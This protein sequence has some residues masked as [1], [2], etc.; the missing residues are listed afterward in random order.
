[1]SDENRRGLSWLYDDPAGVVESRRLAVD[2]AG[3]SIPV[4]PA[5]AAGQAP[6]AHLAHM[7]RWRI[8]AWRR[9]AL[10]AESSMAAHRPSCGPRLRDSWAPAITFLAERL[11]RTEG[12]LCRVRPACR[13][14]CSMTWTGACGMTP[15]AVDPSSRSVMNRMKVL[16]S[17]SC[18][19]A[20]DA[21]C[22]RGGST[23]S[24]GTLQRGRERR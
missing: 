16:C 20:A 3:P 17:L 19:A 14:R 1:M 23:S 9:S 6:G 2:R 18:N 21:W 5:G 11:K 8:C 15:E 10:S 12:W 22:C 4:G 7:V 13:R 24:Q